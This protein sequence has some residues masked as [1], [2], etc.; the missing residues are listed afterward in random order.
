MYPSGAARA[1]IS[2]PMLPEAPL[3]FS[4]TIRVPSWPP[5]GSAMNRAVMSTLP[6]GGNGAISLIGCVG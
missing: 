3:R 2:I 6:P 4:M 5:S 1:A